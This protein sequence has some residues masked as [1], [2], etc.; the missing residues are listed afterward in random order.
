MWG[1]AFYSR[2]ENNWLTEL[3]HLEE[4]L[5]THK[6]SLTPSLFIE[7]SCTKPGKWA[8]ISNYNIGKILKLVHKKNCEKHRPLSAASNSELQ[9]TLEGRIYNCIAGGIIVQVPI[10][11]YKHFIFDFLS[12]KGYLMAVSLYN[13]LTQELVFTS[14]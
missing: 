13:Y 14:F 1:L 11:L 10:L 4:R 12:W 3:F 9:L 6:T 7:N 5:W 2:V 8:V